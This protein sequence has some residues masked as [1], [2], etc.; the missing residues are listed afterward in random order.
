M[1]G[2]RKTD[3]E[4]GNLVLETKTGESTAF[5]AIRQSPPGRM[6]E[7]CGGKAAETVG[8]SLRLLCLIWG[9]WNPES[10]IN[11]FFYWLLAV[12]FF[13]HLEAHVK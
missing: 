5:Q 10:M 13:A 3:Q 1:S 11:W 6:G 4:A 12:K 9:T 2:R 7:Q 8:V